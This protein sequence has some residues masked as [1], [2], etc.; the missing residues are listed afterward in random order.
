MPILN[1]LSTLVFA[2]MHAVLDKLEDPHTSLKLAV[3]E[4]ECA[5]AD[6]SQEI[7]RHKAILEKQ[8]RHQLQIKEQLAA[9]D[10]ELSICFESDEEA[11]AKAVLRKKLAREDTQAHLR[12]NITE[13]EQHLEQQLVLYRE[14]ERQLSSMREKLAVFDSDVSIS[15][16]NVNVSPCSGETVSEE[17]VE[18][19]YLKELQR[20]KSS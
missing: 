8:H 1:R 6:A 13:L 15:D 5:L 14:N 2:D 19:A 17:A 18:V 16:S 10:E 4:M 3:H 12:K 20:R 11:L 9:F 7:S